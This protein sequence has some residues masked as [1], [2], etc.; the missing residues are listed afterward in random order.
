MRALRPGKGRRT[1]RVLI[2]GGAREIM[3]P[4]RG[5]GRYKNVEDLR[6]ALAD[7]IIQDLALYSSHPMSSC[8][9]SADPDIGPLRADGRMHRLEGL[10]VA[11]AS[12]FPTSLGVNPQY[13]TM[14]MATVLARKM[15]AAG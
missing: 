2:A 15:V 13:T 8:R 4:I 1:A 11:D 10:Y 6:S 3:S 12:V 5:L 14:A 9:M 7:R